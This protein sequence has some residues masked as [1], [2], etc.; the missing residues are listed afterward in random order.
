MIH[1]VLF[2]ILGSLGVNFVGIDPT[3]IML[4]AFV[5]LMLLLNPST[6]FLSKLDNFSRL[7]MLLFVSLYIISCVYGD[8]NNTYIAYFIS[9]GLLFYFI[10]YF[11]LHTRFSYNIG[12]YILIGYFILNIIFMGAGF[13]DFDI[14][15]VTFDVFRDGRYMG[16]TGDPNF[17]GLL[18]ALIVFILIDKVAFRNLGG[19]SLLLNLALL[20]FAIAL[21]LFTQSRT[22]WVAFFAGVLVYLLC[23]RGLTNPKL[24]LAFF[25]TL[26]VTALLSVG[27]I[28][29]SDQLG[30]VSERVR[31]ILVQT[32][33]A[34]AERFKFVYTAASYRVG[35]EHPLGVGPGMTVNYTGLMNADGQPIGS[36]NAYVQIFTENGWAAL[37]ALLLFMSV[38]WFRLYKLAS[39]GWEIGG[40]SCRVLLAGLTATAVFGV[41]HDLLNWRIAWLFPALSI[42][43]AFARGPART[44]HPAKYA[45]A[46]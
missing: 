27:D 9:N 32:D 22:S 7:I 2:L 44:T 25:A 21:M 38:A 28:V 5:P 14:A 37:A 29:V 23:S 42:C 12:A 45:V 31:S 10:Y 24:I 4:F 13:I 46:G 3:D 1:I 20:A 11:T 41:G 17:S 8:R 40:I 6:I 36:H 26:T 15:G 39:E 19:W 34:E 35:L 18:A 16:M 30:S 33:S 43:A